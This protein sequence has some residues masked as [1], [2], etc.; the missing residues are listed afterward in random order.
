MNSGLQTLITSADNPQFK[1]ARKLAQSGRERRKTGLTLLDG[2]HLIQAWQDSGRNLQK[3]LTNATFVQ[4]PEF[5]AWKEAN[6]A[7]SIVVFAPGLY[8]EIAGDEFPSGVLAMVDAPAASEDVDFH[9]DYV[10]L[11]GVQDPGNLGT[12]LR[13]AAAA[14]FSQAVLS[15][16]CAQAWGPKTLRAGMGA[17]FVLQIYESVDLP[18]FLGRYS[19]TVAVTDLDGAVSLFDADL[20]LP[21]AWVF[22]SE[23]EGVS[24]PVLACA[25]LRVKIPMPGQIESLNVSAAAAICLFETVRQRSCSARA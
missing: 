6:P 8:T 10:V 24:A 25:A 22:G 19:G 18:D 11:D 13:S 23:G 12:L 17:H 14:G 5:I 3:I 9:G 16:D 7:V 2:L 1:L 21:V 4:N 20:H 15:S